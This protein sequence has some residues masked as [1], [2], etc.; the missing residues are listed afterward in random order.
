MYFGVLTW[1][2]GLLELC[3][4]VWCWELNPCPLEELPV[5][6]TIEPSLQPAGYT[7]YL[8]WPSKLH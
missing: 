4:V 3:A 8:V 2:S 7:I 1:V 5:L 6:L